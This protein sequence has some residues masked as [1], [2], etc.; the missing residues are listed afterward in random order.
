MRTECGLSQD[1]LHRI[2]ASVTDFVQRMCRLIAFYKCDH[3]GRG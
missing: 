3:E 2:A 1:H